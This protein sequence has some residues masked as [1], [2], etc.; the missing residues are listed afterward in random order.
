MSLIAEKYSKKS[1]VVGQTFRL[2]TGNYQLL[3]GRLIPLGDNADSFIKNGYDINDTIYSIINLILDKVRVAPWAVYK[4]I[5]ESSLKGYQ[6]LQQK[7]DMSPEDYKKS[8]DLRTKAFELVKS[9]GKIGELLKYPNDYESMQDF[10]ANGCGYKLLTG[11][12]CIWGDILPG[13][14]NKGMPNKLWVMPSQFVR[15]M[16]AGG[17]PAKIL[18]YEIPN[19]GLTG[20]SSFTPEEVL[21]EKYMNY[22]FSVN[23]N[24][25]LGT[26]PLKAAIR[27]INNSNSALNVA[28]AKFQNG[29]ME[30]IIYYDGPNPDGEAAMPQ[31]TA[32]K[33]K[34][35]SEYSGEANAGKLGVSGYKVGVTQLGYTPVELDI[36]KAEINNIRFLCNVFGVP[37]QLLND[38]ENKSFNNSKEGEKALTSRCALPL[39]IS[40]RDNLNRKFITDWGMDKNW[41]ID[42]NMDVYSEL[43]TDMGETIKWVEP[44][45]RIT[46]LPPNRVLELMGQEKISNPIFDEPWI[47]NNM[48]QP[49][50]EWEMNEVDN[51]LN[52]E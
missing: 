51:V 4:I 26:A 47:N 17:F 16:V 13:G 6:A 38:P 32:L 8:I 34:M 22:D 25:L 11:N 43:Q 37:S 15:L 46:G 21:H 18:G 28:T 7:R 50:S 35:I 42:F 40:T 23:G 1:Q 3:N 45:A 33:Q 31:M 48:G 19:L 12:K 9:P 49:I 39:L 36:I 5:D 10:V 52:N 30:A 41:C 44:M 27:R 2:S 24:H 14:A 20:K 29:G